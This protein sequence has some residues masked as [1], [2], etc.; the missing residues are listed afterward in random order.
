MEHVKDKKNYCTEIF[1]NKYQL[2]SI[3]AYM[4][5][6]IPQ[7]QHRELRCRAQKETKRNEGT[8]NDRVKV[9]RLP[10]EQKVLQYNTYDIDHHLVEWFENSQPPIEE[11]VR[12]WS[13]TVGTPVTE[14]K[15]SR[16]CHGKLIE[17]MQE[18]K[19]N[20]K[21]DCSDKD[22]LIPGSNTSPILHH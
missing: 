22:M 7:K 5:I 18:I 17:L 2:Q 12:D 13:C 9:Q 4:K 15:S 16:F 11:A 19:K 1:F 14:I 6:T 3:P 20:W 10:W 8:Y 21:E